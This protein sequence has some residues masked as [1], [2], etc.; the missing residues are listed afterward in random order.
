MAGGLTGF[1]SATGGGGTGGKTGGYAGGNG[2]STTGGGGGGGG[3]GGN[4]GGGAV[5]YSGLSARPAQP[6]AEGRSSL[7]RSKSAYSGPRQPSE[8]TE[9]CRSQIRPL[10]PAGSR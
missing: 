3:R 9:T 10:G 4:V 5:P 7:A 1:G 6:K 8:R 2:G